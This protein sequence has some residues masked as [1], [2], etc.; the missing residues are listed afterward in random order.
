[1]LSRSLKSI[2]A[3]EEFIGNDDLDVRRCL[4]AKLEFQPENAHSGRRHLIEEAIRIATSH[5]DPYI[6]HCAD[7]QLGG[8]V[9]FMALPR[10]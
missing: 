6:R 5:S 3:R 7:I 8:S 10:D 2:G 4:I 1:M 9:P